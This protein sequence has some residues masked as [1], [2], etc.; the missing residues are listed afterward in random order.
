M[1]DNHNLTWI[2]LNL[3][4]EKY[5][6]NPKT[7]NK[8]FTKDKKEAVEDFLKKYYSP[9]IWL[10][11]DPTIVSPAVFEYILVWYLETD[12]LDDSTR[13][14]INKVFLASRIKRKSSLSLPWVYYYD[15]ITEAQIEKT[16]TDFSNLN[17]GAIFKLSILHIFYREK[18]GAITKNQYQDFFVIFNK[19]FLK[20]LTYKILYK[21]LYNLELTNDLATSFRN[22]PTLEEL[23]NHPIYGQAF[24][25]YHLFLKANGTINSSIL[26]R[27]SNL[28][29]FINFL[30]SR[31]VRQ[32]SEI[33]EDIL[34]DYINEQLRLGLKESSISVLFPN[35]QHFLDWS[36]GSYDFLPNTISYPVALLSKI[37][38]A[39]RIA[40]QDSDGLAFT[41]ER[42][43]DLTLEFL[44]EFKPQNEI[45]FLCSRF[46][47][48]IASCATRQAFVLNLEY[49][50]CMY[51]MLNEKHIYGLYSVD[52]D[53]AGNKHGHFPILDQLGVTAI[54]EL[55]ER[56]RKDI[57]F[58]KPIKKRN[59]SNRTYIHLFQ[60]KN[61]NRVLD[62]NQIYNFQKDHIAPFIAKKIG[63]EDTKAIEFGTH[64]FRHYL[65]T[66]IVTKTG[67]EETAQ[68]AAGHHDGQ[69]IRRNYIKSKF[70]KKALLNRAISKYENGEITGKFYLR[71]IEKLT[72]ETDLNS[73]IMK[74]LEG[75]MELESFI[76]KHGR[77]TEMGY[78]FDEDH[79][80]NQYMKCWNCPSFMMRREEVS[81]AINLL[82][83]LIN[84]Y[85]RMRD[86]SKNFTHENTLVQNNLRAIAMIKERLSDLKYTDEQIETMLYSEHI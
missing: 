59:K 51:P 26:A 84:D 38:S 60:L 23:S 24:I 50:N 71:L 46:W 4:L 32:T 21:I 74:D 17:S 83:K 44:I 49:N 85:I 86:H 45:E 15:F 63:I 43:P 9:E 53:K 55:E 13:I 77:P 10:D 70:A 22:N 14:K 28:K 72:N 20:P 11:N 5:T 8:A 42:F 61:S 56:I 29:K 34:S 30:D 66:H 78:C 25:D 16:K 69:M 2:E 27:F 1:T 62:E 79:S 35:I 82:R 57:F 37:R 75:E 73:E 33:N 6:D 80:C 58:F 67:D 31:G 52:T 64:A 39:A 68:A 18:I 65:L 54:R 3:F 12:F 48:V 76:K 47:M 7:H 81:G 36:I 40:R 19:S 41:D